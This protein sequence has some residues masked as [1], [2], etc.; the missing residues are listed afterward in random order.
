MD[1]LIQLR[2]PQLA[3]KPDENGLSHA[4]TEA[5]PPMP[6]ELLG[7]VAEA[8]NQ[9]EEDRE[10]L[11][12]TRQ[13]EHAVKQFEQ[14]YRIYAGTLTRRQAR[15][16]RQAQTSFDNASEER[17]KA[18]S[19]FQLA[20][21]AAAAATVSHEAAKRSLLGARARLETLQSDPANQDANRLSQAE[22]DAKDRQ[23]EAT[24]SR[25]KCDVAKSHLARE[26]ERS[27]QSHQRRIDSRRRV[28]IISRRV[29]LGSRIG[30]HGSIARRKSTAG[31]SARQTRGTCGYAVR[32]RRNRIAG[33]YEQIVARASGIW[34]NDMQFLLPSSLHSRLHKNDNASAKQNW[35][36]LGNG[37]QRRI[38]TRKSPALT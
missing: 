6:P 16:L 34:K 11:E 12:K 31:T 8:L 37:E 15:E 21:E 26:E 27:R 25:E 33:S 29:C 3:R 1:T 18:Q 5:L 2:Q 20:E 9:L 22:K 24:A 28:G 14:R 19:A 10:Q 4:L 23:S 17:N 30:W 36:K 35:R 13:L 32:I 38:R 7:D